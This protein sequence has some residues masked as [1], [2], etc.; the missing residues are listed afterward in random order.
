MWLVCFVVLF[1]F[2]GKEKKCESA[3][4]YRCLL[5]ITP[6]R[7]RMAWRNNQPLCCAIR[8]CQMTRT[9]KTTSACSRFRASRAVAAVLCVVRVVFVVVAW[10]SFVVVVVRVLPGWFVG[11]A[12][13]LASWLHDGWSAQR[14]DGRRQRLKNL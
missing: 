6:L 1:V 4:V 10:L 5:V 8:W 2:G 13:W 12:G 9:F 14:C 11:L 7:G 3:K